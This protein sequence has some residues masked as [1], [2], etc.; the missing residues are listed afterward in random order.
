MSN[1]A[2]CQL[3]NASTR[4][5]ARHLLARRRLYAEVR[6]VS[7]DTTIALLAADLHCEHKRT[8]AD[9]IVYATAR[10]QGIDLPACDEHFEGLHGV[11]LFPK[12]AQP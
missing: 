10:Q 8:T 7:L 12:T 5:K 9:A 11:T 4:T 3:R 6:G 2:L 1:A